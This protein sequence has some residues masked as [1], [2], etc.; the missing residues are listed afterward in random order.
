MYRQKKVTNG[1]K[2]SSEMINDPTGESGTPQLEKL[3]LWVSSGE[4]TWRPHIH[5]DAFESS[6]SRQTP[7]KAFVNCSLISPSKATVP[8][9]FS[10]L[11]QNNVL[12]KKK[13]PYD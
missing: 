3:Q 8:F 9:T 7:C 13:C 1:A 12:K 11:I 4:E 10:G 2:R 6:D 5:L